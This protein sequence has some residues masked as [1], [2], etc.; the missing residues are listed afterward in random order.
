MEIQGDRRCG[1][2]TISY[3]V[4]PAKKKKHQELPPAHHHKKKPNSNAKITV[5]WGRQEISKNKK[6]GKKKGEC[7]KFTERKKNASRTPDQENGEQNN[8]W[9]ETRGKERGEERLPPP[10]RDGVEK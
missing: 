7:R 8:N 10:G 9:R 3:S 1:T 4:P 6:G 2:S 5:A